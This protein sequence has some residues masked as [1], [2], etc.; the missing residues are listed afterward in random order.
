MNDTIAQGEHIP[1]S[2]IERNPALSVIPVT[3]SFS[4]SAPES[5]SAVVDAVAAPGTSASGY[6]VGGTKLQSGV[7]VTA[8]ARQ[9]DGQTRTTSYVFDVVPAVAQTSSLALHIGKPVLPAD[10]PMAPRPAFAAPR[11]AVPASRYNDHYPNVE[12]HN[13]RAVV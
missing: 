9:A 5:I 8:T 7:T 3:V 4:Y 12:P 2:L 10:A 6:F 13:A 11:D 1:F